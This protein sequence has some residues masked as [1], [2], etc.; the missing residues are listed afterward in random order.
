MDEEYR[1]RPALPLTGSNNGVH[2]KDANGR[3]IFSSSRPDEEAMRDVA[4]VVAT[5]NG[6]DML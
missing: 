3:Q 6:H 2:I 5:V 1:G 4:F